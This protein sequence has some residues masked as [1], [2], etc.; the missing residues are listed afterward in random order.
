MKKTFPLHVP[1]KESPAV[2]KAIQL[3]ITK[4]VK[5]EKRKTLPPEVDFWYFNCKVG[6]DSG[7]ASPVQLPDLPKAIKGVALAGGTEVYVEI[8][9][10][11]GKRVKK[12][13]PATYHR[14]EP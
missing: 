9:A 10:S 1:G 4:Y 3:E 8:M 2:V 7:S 5:R 12:P 13:H 6:S 11:A 14:R